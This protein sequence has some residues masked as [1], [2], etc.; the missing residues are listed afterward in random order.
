MFPVCVNKID[1]FKEWNS[2]KIGKFYFISL[3]LMSLP[4][5]L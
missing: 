4:Y 5:G 2:S 3:A 1:L